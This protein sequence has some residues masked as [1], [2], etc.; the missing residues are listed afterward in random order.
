MT[1]GA[2][3]YTHVWLHVEIYKIEKKYILIPQ[4][5]LNIRRENEMQFLSISD[6]LKLLT[7]NDLYIKFSTY[8]DEEMTVLLY[9]KP[10]ILE[11]G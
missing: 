1:T 10:Y 9:E 4:D 2:P 3:G 8:E 6:L 11:I 7:R 5:V